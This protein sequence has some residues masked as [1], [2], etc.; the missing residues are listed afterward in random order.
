MIQVEP[1]WGPDLGRDP[2]FEIPKQADAYWT[3]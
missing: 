2:L 1:I 3:R